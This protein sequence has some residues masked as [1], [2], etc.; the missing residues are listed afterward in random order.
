MNKDK[1]KKV[2]Y[3]IFIKYQGIII[4]LV[5]IDQIT[6][7]IALNYFKTPIKIFGL[8]WLQFRLV[9]NK[10]VAFSM[11]D[12]A[13]LWTKAMIS[14]VAFILIEAYIIVKKPEDKIFKTMLLLVAA[15]ALG[16]GIDRW[17]AVFPDVTGYEGVVDFI[18]VSWFAN[19]NV[20]DIYVTVTCLGMIVYMLLTSDEVKKVKDKNTHE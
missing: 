6:K 1:I 5:I 2:L 4:L 7:I 8:D 9:F 10:G 18:Y 15:G 16:N 3:D 12:D 14:L 17:L 19:F 13:P 11:L 20:A